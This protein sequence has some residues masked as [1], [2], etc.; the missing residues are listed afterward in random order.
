MKPTDLMDEAKQ[1][2][3]ERDEAISALFPAPDQAHIRAIVKAGMNEM[4]GYQPDSEEHE[5]GIHP[6]TGAAKLI[7]KSLPNIDLQIKKIIGSIQEKAQT[8]CI[9]GKGTDTALET[10]G[11]ELDHWAKELSFENDLKSERSCSRIEYTLQDFCSRIP[12]D[13]R[14]HIYEVVKEIGKEEKLPNKL[15]KIELALSFILNKWPIDYDIRKKL[16][17]IKMS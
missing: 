1:K 16:D 11:L 2:L 7:K 13:K 6:G 3:R 5:I 17:E 8:I 9:Q 10:A 12:V 14:F 4:I 15:T